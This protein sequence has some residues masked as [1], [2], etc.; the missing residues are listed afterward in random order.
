MAKSEPAVAFLIIAHHQPAHLARLIG[1]LRDERAGFFV[2]VDAR[3][4]IAPFAP[5]ERSP[6][7]WL[8]DPRVRVFWGGL[9]AVEA[10]LLLLRSAI[11]EQRFERFCLL[12]GA[13]F[14]IKGREEIVATLLGSNREFLSVDARLSGAPRDSHFDHIERIHANDWELFNS[15][16]PTRHPRLQYACCRSL[17]RVA[18]ILPRRR[19]YPGITPYQGSAY[20][21]LT[22]PCVEHI[23]RF[24]SERPDYARFHRWVHV[25]DEIFFHS[26][27]KASPFASRISDDFER[28]PKA[29][30]ELACHFIDWH[31]EGV[32]LPKVLDETDYPRLVESPALFARK[33][34]ES[35]SRR[36]VEML[37]ATAST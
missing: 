8:A 7:V 25:P 23:L 30:F 22:R 6:D 11:R 34:D 4:E 9:S 20:W 5:I 26:I 32:R 29:R 18:R 33:F 2:H 10:T 14:P 36:L 19:F 15:N 12:S 17:E 16:A 3:T 35:R 27:I 13:D 28:G 31:A 1:A 21:C 37:E 24:L